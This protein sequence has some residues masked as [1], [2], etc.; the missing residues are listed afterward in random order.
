MEELITAC[1]LFLHSYGIEPMDSVKRPIVTLNTQAEIVKI[2]GAPAA[3]AC[4]DGHIYMDNRINLASIEAQA[5]VCHEVVH[6]TQGYCKHPSDLADRM[7]KERQ[8]YQAQNQYLI[9]HGVKKRALDPFNPEASGEGLTK[10]VIITKGLMEVKPPKEES[11]ETIR[12]RFKDI[13]GRQDKFTKRGF[14]SRFED[15]VLDEETIKEYNS[16]TR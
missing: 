11:A 7:Y 16:R 12:R 13:E 9:D 8:A 2:A 5:M 3:G 10:P 6:F 14:H 4:L 15:G 1:F